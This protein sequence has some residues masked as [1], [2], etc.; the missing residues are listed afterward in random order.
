MLS[1]VRRLSLLIPLV[2]A[3]LAAHSE[4]AD[5]NR[6][7]YINENFD[8]KSWFYEGTSSG[9][10]YS[11]TNRGTYKIDAMKSKGVGSSIVQDKIGDFELSVDARLLDYDEEVMGGSAGGA[12]PPRLWRPGGA[13]S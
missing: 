6:Q 2:A 7:P 12:F 9:V 1:F 3:F 10:T 8:A 11:Y 13:F 5:L 4:A